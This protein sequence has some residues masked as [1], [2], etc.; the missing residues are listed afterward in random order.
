PEVLQAE[1]AFFSGEL[2]PRGDSFEKEFQFEFQGEF[3]EISVFVPRGQE[4]LADVTV[5][6]FP[7][8]SIS[9][10]VLDAHENVGQFFGK[11]TFG[12]TVFPWK[13]ASDTKS[14]FVTFHEVI[15]YNR[16]SKELQTVFAPYN[17]GNAVLSIA[18]I[19][20]NELVTISPDV[21]ISILDK[22][23]VNPDITD[24]PEFKMI[25][26]LPGERSALVGF[27]RDGTQNEERFSIQFSGIFDR[28]GNEISDQKYTLMI[29]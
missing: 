16:L 21:Q 14:P 10:S 24:Q 8:Q 17:S 28:W 7:Q 25:E 27:W 5:S 29:R 19:H 15:P 13:E 23:F 6:T 2:L 18:E 20:F 9:S 12:R 26:M 1:P 3:N 22:D 11:L 4:I